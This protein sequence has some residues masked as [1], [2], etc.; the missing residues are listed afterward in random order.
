[1]TETE[2]S[3]KQ[4]TVKYKVIGVFGPR[5]DAQK[6]DFNDGETVNRYLNR[7]AQEHKTIDP[8][9]VLRFVTGGSRGV[10]L[11]A[12]EWCDQHG[13]AHER[14]KPVKGVVDVFGHRNEQIIRSCDGL[15][16]FW[17][18]VC[19]DTSRLIRQAISHG[20]ETRIIPV[21]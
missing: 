18:S 12:E 13:Y 2:N 6:Q 10:E 20:R 11:L 15:L 16:V 17:D 9:H 3:S 14:I 8:T 5:F 4:E 1:M 21:L 7:L 19:I